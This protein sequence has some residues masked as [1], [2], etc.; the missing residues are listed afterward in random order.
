[1]EQW[2]SPRKIAEEE[3]DYKRQRF[4]WYM[5]EADEGRLPREIAIR[6]LREEIEGIVILEST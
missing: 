3:R 5:V 4:E 6:A 2:K 1:M